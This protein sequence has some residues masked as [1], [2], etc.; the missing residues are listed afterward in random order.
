M[1]DMLG[2]EFGKGNVRC[3]DR[4]PARARR[5]M[6][7]G[8]APVRVD[9]SRP[10]D[11][12]KAA[13]G[14]DLVINAGLPDFNLK[15]MAAALSVGAN[16]QD[17]C[18]RLQDLRH[19]E[20]L[21]FHAR[22]RRAGRVALFNTGV[23]PGLT[24]LLAAE[25][26]SG[27]DRTRAI[28]IRLLEEQDADEPVMSWSPRVIVDE[29]ASPPL[30][31]RAGRF[32]NVKPFSGAETFVFPKPFGP[33]RVVA[34]Y[35]DE[36]ATIPLYLKVREVDMKSGGTDIDF[37]AAL[38][39]AGL[40]G[41]K[42]V[43]IGRERVRPRDMLEAVAPKVP[44]PEEMR[45]LVEKGSVRNSWLLASVEAEGMLDGRRASRTVTAVFP[46]LRQ[47]MRLRPG[48]TYVSYPTALCAAAFS[49]IMPRIRT[50]GAM[51]PEALD[52]ALRKT[53][54]RDLKNAG[55]VF[56]RRSGKG[57]RTKDRV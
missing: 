17:L 55:V 42:P 30:V 48:A 20:Q 12:A 26:A 50:T 14:A 36:V 23:A 5:F 32:G 52:G 7:G 11:V 53:V 54:L 24:N 19:A 18:S 9:A 38:F 10:A 39:A 15:V 46:D 45:R 33:R 35:G 44:T 29:L 47:V 34:V 21:R 4:D 6:S 31:L 40:L 49:R 37:G 28:R 16:Y 22:F 1:A 57:Q 43:T 56:V 25:L 2:K 13:K 3:G 27:L 51:P 41:S 8:A